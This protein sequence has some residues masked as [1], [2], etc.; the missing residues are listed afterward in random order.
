MNGND[1]A[2]EE[3]AQDALL[4]SALR[5]EQADVDVDPKRLPEL[6]DEE[7]AAMRSLGNDLIDKLLAEDAKSAELHSGDEDDDFEETD[8]L[9]FAG[10][11]SG[12]G[13]NR[14]EIIDALTAEEIE[15]KKKEILDRLANENREKGANGS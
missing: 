9:A 3:R 6:S 5:R 1:R 14:A 8:D 12:W 10:S 13:L 2:R 15:R 11:A 4:I 7:K